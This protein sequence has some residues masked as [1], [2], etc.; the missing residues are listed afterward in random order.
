MCFTIFK[1]SHLAFEIQKFSNSPKHFTL[2]QEIH[3]AETQDSKGEF[4]IEC[5]E[6]EEANEEEGEEDGLSK[7]SRGD[8]RTYQGFGET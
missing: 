5:D 3:D 7:I 4:Q 8:G 1:F 2:K 6:E